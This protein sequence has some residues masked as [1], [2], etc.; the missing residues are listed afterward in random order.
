MANFTTPI[1]VA[2]GRYLQGFHRMLIA[3][4]PA[5]A[6]YAARPFAKAAVWAP[7]RMVDQVDDMMG[8][9]EGLQVFDQW[10]RD[11]AGH[12]AQKSVVAATADE[13]A[14]ATTTNKDKKVV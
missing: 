14:A 10:V 11:F 5:L 13:R 9:A 1:R 4:T 6:E 3:D 2:F 8:E 7:G 12:V